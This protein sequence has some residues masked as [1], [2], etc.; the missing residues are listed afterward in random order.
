MCVAVSNVLVVAY[1]RRSRQLLCVNK[2]SVPVQKYGICSN[3]MFTMCVCVVV[4]GGGGLGGGLKFSNSV[5]KITELYTYVN[6]KRTSG[7][8]GQ[9]FD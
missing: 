7:F 2:R 6:Y 4:K 3:K 1:N 9:S 5:S 8:P